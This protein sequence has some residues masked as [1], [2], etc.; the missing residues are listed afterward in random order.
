ETSSLVAMEALAC[1]T[2]VIAFRAGALVEIVDHGKTGFLVDNEREMAQAIEAVA[3]LDPQTC[4]DAAVAR[5]SAE[6]MIRDYFTVYHGLAGSRPH[7]D[8]CIA[9]KIVE[10][11]SHDRFANVI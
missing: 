1:G 2:P 11:E 7:R 4:R 10:L 3:Q 9:S 6:R 8:S 5:F